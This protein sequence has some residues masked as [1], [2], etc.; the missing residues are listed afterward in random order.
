LPVPDGSIR[1]RSF[2]RWKGDTVTHS[3]ERC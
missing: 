1:M 2:T 3:W